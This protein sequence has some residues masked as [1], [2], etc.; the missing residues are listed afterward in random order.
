VQIEFSEVSYLSCP[1]DFSDASFRHLSRQECG[2][3]LESFADYMQEDG[4][5]FAVD[6]SRFYDVQTH[7]IIAGALNYSFGKVYYY[8]REKLEPGE[9]IAPWVLTGRQN[10]T[11]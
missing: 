2:E 5:V 8:R 9:S 3:L 10:V 4:S 7:Y 11:S 6:L 1:T